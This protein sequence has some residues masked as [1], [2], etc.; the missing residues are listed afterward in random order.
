METDLT[1]NPYTE[2]YRTFSNS[3]L[4]EVLLKEYDYQ[5]LAVE[6]AKRE[7]ESRRLSKEEI[8]EAMMIVNI[9]LEKIAKKQQQTSVVTTK[10]SR[11]M[12]FIHYVLIVVGILSIL[13]DF[14]VSGG[15]H[16]ERSEVLKI[17]F[18]LG[19]IFWKF[20]YGKNFLD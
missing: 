7:I 19:L 10:I 15:S 16:T 11:P 4:F 3:A 2:L 13:S 8:S 14:V 12:N 20:F 9:K 17:C 1:E 6:T 5:P 18:V